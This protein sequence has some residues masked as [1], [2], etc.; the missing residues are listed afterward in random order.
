MG[1]AGW[2]YNTK[3]Q[4]VNISLINEKMLKPLKILKKFLWHVFFRP[5]KLFFLISKFI[6]FSQQIVFDQQNYSFCQQN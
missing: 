5:A 3:E 4:N 1:Y 2:W 6:A